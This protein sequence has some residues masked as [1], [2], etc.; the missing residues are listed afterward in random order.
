M[1]KLNTNHW[2]SLIF[3]IIGWVVGWYSIVLISAE[4][5]NNKFP[6][7]PT[8]N[9]WIGGLFAVFIAILSWGRYIFTI[10]GDEDHQG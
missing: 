1:I 8:K 2:I 4:Y 5:N 3:S 9:Q 7:M 6:L 10:Q